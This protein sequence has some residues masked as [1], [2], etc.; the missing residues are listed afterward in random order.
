MS[1]SFVPIIVELLVESIRASAFAPPATNKPPANKKTDRKRFTRTSAE[2]R[3]KK[4]PEIV[5]DFEGAEIQ[6]TSA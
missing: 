5:L 3:Y 4:L 1:T 6:S 2:S